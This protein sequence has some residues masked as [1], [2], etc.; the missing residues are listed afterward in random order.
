MKALGLDPVSFFPTLWELVPYSWAIDYFTNIGDLIY[1]ASYGGCDVLWASTGTKRFS[2]YNAKTGVK[3]NSPAPAGWHLTQAYA[4]V[5]PS[6]VV[7]EKAVISRAPYFGS[8]V[9]FPEF[10]VPGLSLKWLN[11]GAAFLQ[12]SLAFL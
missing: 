12:R 8:Y 1:G 11:L 7:T 3:L 4:T 5:S 10:R 6:E 2:R 9:P